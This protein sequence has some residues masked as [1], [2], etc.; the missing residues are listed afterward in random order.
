MNTKTR[1]IYHDSS[2][3]VRFLMVVLLTGISYGLYK[4]VQDN[5]LA[6]LV[7]INEFER[8]IVEFFR[9][10]PGLLLIFILAT[11]YR[12]SE[13]KVFK[14][15]TAI[16]LAGALGLV[17]FSTG[18]VVVVLFMVV[19]SLGEHMVMP[20][21]NTISLH[22]A[23]TGKGG[24][25]LGVTSA[26]NNAGNIAGYLLVTVLFLLFPRFGLAKNSLASFKIIFFL[27]AVL[28]L[29]ATLVS[30]AMVDHGTTVKRQRLF[31]A[32]K[33]GKYYGLEVFYGARKQVFMTFAPYVLILHYGANASVIALLLAISAIFGMIFSPLIGRLIDYAGYK[34][35]MVTDTLALVIVCFF[36][37][38]SHRL[39][40]AHI[41][42][43]VVCVNYVLDS[44][45]SLCAIASSV[46][47]QDIATN[48]EEVTATLTTGISVNHL[49]SVLIALLGGWI[50]KITG[51][52]V[53]FTL[54]AILGIINSIFA[55]SIKLPKK[56]E[57]GVKTE[58]QIS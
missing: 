41:A 1:A 44:I 43:Y 46:Y 13:T 40:P 37:G 5:Y 36:Y 35:V 51:I 26:M 45:I 31:F 23:K 8:G 10:L 12:F 58:P 57:R 2:K 53:L 38:F 34:F 29:G 4:G 54:S 49:I 52:E 56:G 7:H 6:E 15:G 22:F 20:V 17:L 55:A 24:S 27:S 19:Y 3:V 9:E 47:V 39:F 11:L 30:L 50:W 16:T 48:Q 18:K 33:Y 32:R 42:F 21:K 14:V 28:L 25:S